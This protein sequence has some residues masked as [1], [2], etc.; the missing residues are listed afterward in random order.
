MLRMIRRIL[1]SKVG[2]WFALAFV[3]LVGVAFAGADLSGT[4]SGLGTN[5]GGGAPGGTV[6]TVGDREV[7]E[8]DL[9]NRVQ[10]AY[11]AAS[12]R[13]P[14]LSL[15]D[16]VTGGGFDATVDRVLNAV[17]LEEFAL[18]QRL[19]ASKKL[20]DG[21]IA[22]EP[23]FLG[24]TGQFDPNVFRRV[25]AENGITE[26]QVR[27]DLRTDVLTRQ[28]LSPVTA[29]AYVPP[30][31]ARR[32]AALSLETRTGTLLTIPSASMPKGP[33]P[34]DAEVAGFYARNTARY[35]VPELR[36]IRIARFGADTLAAKA[37][38][39]DA[40]VAA[41]YTANATRFGSS[42]R[43]SITQV[44]FF[45]Q[46]AAD[47]FAR[48]VRGGQLMAD[49]AKAAGLRPLVVQDQD[50]AAYARANGDAP[51]A[52]VWGAQ[53]GALL[54]AVRSQGALVVAR[55]DRVSRKPAEPL[56]AARPTII[57]ELSAERLATLLSELDERLYSR[58][59]DGES[60]PDIAKAEGLRV[61][62]T[63]ALTAAGVDPNAPSAEPVLPAALATRF[64]AL[65]TDDEPIID[66]LVPNE[67][68]F[69]GDVARVVPAAPRPLASIRDR[70]AADV[71]ADR[72]QVAARKLTDS[73]VARVRGGQSLAAAAKVAGIALPPVQPL[74][75][76]RL[77]LEQAQGQVPP[78]LA[79]LFAMAPGTAKRIAGPNGAGYGIVALGNVTGG[80]PARANA[81]VQSTSR[82]LS[83]TFGTEYGLQ[84]A[85]AARSSVGERRVDADLA[86]LKNSM[87]GAAPAR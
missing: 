12:D 44:T 56:S 78:P 27:D 43:R 47:S 82:Q 18:G 86:A 30:S 26:A 37:Q 54:P 9:R 1:D 6:L 4:L 33:A 50:R 3:G 52:A 51:A 59:S 15:A 25:L 83:S 16:F 75:A 38:P 22:S 58:V 40:D 10:G 72:Q 39:S 17:G 11:R 61:E 45:D 87:A 71:V 76:S 66:A 35:T 24:A 32:Y 63:P 74:K 48:S 79:L 29:V 67:R 8:E 41:F 55:V 53:E 42:E 28:L 20:V 19:V 85:R 7:G 49:A 34:T 70:V 31:I 5:L 57:K 80:E 84:F 2:V 73:I 77:Q 21:R 14:G 64:A 62:L 23:G 60:L 81:L 68:F 36:V 65:S 13:Q 46:A 69:I